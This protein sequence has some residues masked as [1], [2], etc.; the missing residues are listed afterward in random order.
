MAWSSCRTTS[1]VAARSAIAFLF[2]GVHEPVTHFFAIFCAGIRGWWAFM[3]GSVKAE[4]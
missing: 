2:F 3:I 1:T 4:T